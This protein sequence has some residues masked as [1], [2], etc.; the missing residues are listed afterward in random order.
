M[1]T[2]PYILR[3][4]LICCFVV[5][6]SGLAEVGNY[7]VKAPFYSK[8]MMLS[9]GQIIEANVDSGSSYAFTYVG[10]T[11]IDI[12]FSIIE[13][14]TKTGSSAVMNGNSQLE[15]HRMQRPIAQS[16][17]QQT[18]T[19]ES[20]FQKEQRAEHDLEEALG[21]RFTDS[22]FRNAGIAAGIANAL[23]EM[24]AVKGGKPEQY[25]PS[26]YRF[27]DKESLIKK[28]LAEDGNFPGLVVS[29]VQQ[30]PN[31][32]D[33]DQ[34]L[35]IAGIQAAIKNHAVRIY[36]AAE[37]ETRPNLPI[38]TIPGQLE[39]VTMYGDRYSARTTDGVV[40]EGTIVQ[41]IDCSGNGRIVTKPDNS[42]TE[43]TTLVTPTSRTVIP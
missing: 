3:V 4:L 22:G 5:V 29:A 39:T 15:E 21:P 7:L 24:A 12:P 14:A 8:G 36:T 42:S 43:I 41:Q 6:P 32:R 10:Q 18:A 23:K 20:Q 26:E 11:R 34:D 33:A 2:K 27:S 19:G 40:H 31:A 9:P 13:P 28:A 37:I 1:K 25:I 16:N 30:N 17:P 35:K 38:P